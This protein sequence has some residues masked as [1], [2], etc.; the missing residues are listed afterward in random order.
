MKRCN[1]I[2]NT[3]SGQDSW[4]NKIDRTK[5]EVRMG[6]Y[7]CKHILEIAIEE[8]NWKGEPPAIYLPTKQWSKLGVDFTS[9]WV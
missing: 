8:F 3:G 5:D 9:M 2:S 4:D 1:H 6:E 7:G